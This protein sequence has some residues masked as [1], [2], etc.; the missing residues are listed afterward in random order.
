MKTE[1]QQQKKQ[2][3]VILLI[4]FFG[5]VGISLPYLIFPSLFLNHDF[6]IIPPSWNDSSRA[7]FLG[8][9]LAAYPLGQFI[10][11]PILGSLSDDFGRKKLLCA[12]L[13]IAAACN[14]LAGLAITREHLGLLIASR[15]ITGLM[16]GNVAI[17]RAMASDL[18]SISKHNSFGKI[19]AA[20]SI[21]FLV[22]P[23]LGGMMTDKDLFQNLTASSPF[24]LTAYL[25]LFLSLIS[26]AVLQS[27]TPKKE[28]QTKS[29]LERINIFKRL[30]QLFLNKQ[31]RALLIVSTFFTLAVD[32]FYEFGPVYL[33]VK[34]S[35]S[36]SELV[37]FN[38]VLCLALVIGNGWFPSLISSRFAHKWPII[39][40]IMAFAVFL[41]GMV[42]VNTPFSM[43]LLFSLSGFAIGIGVTL[44]TVN[45][46]DAVNETIQGEVMGIQQSLR[47]LGD[48][49][50]CLFGGIFLIISSKLILLIASLICLL[51]TIY[52][53]SK[54][55][56]MSEW[57]EIK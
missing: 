15:F 24:Y 49:V 20:A 46:S 44:L 37:V 18:T 28:I 17:A 48:A 3:L 30:T 35:V 54:Y 10:G 47:F 55:K 57:S 19:N 22:G 33:T 9:T 34:W 31:L 42:V 41:I 23:L 40:S 56:K 13:V 4:V 26:F 39:C 43:M 45:I 36:P 21:A 52:Y 16:E 1:K 53:K 29:F 38:G 7:I 5:F 25:Y 50:I 32:I 14:A 8:I 51:S 6:A 11:S 12:S 27:D 2:F